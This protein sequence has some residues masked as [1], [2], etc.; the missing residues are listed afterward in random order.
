MVECPACGHEFEPDDDELP[1]FDGPLSVEG[2]AAAILKKYVPS[3]NLGERL[4]LEDAIKKCLVGQLG[5][6]PG[7]L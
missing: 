3:F 7:K 2:G 6:S 4:A 1:P 5:V